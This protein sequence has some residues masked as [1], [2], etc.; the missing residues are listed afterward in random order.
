MRMS[1]RDWNLAVPRMKDRSE[2]LEEGFLLIGQKMR[3]KVE[4]DGKVYLASAWQIGPDGYVEM[5]EV[6]ED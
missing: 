5:N 1:F 4:L 3:A 2:E 6:K